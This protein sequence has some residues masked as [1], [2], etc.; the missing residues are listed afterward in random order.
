[1]TLSEIRLSDA[2]YI[3]FS[4]FWLLSNVSCLRTKGPSASCPIPFLSS[5][6]CFLILLPVVVKV[7]HPQVCE[8]RV[9]DIVS[10]C[11]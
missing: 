2:D 11:I 10:L 3:V 8:T 1:M 7:S 4:K 6:T 9:K 5:Q